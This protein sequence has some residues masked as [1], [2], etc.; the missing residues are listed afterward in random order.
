MNRI[1]ITLILLGFI[2]SCKQEY[3]C[4]CIC[5]EHVYYDF[6]DYQ[7]LSKNEVDNAENSCMN[8]NGT[9]CITDSIGTLSSCTLLEVP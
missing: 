7:S 2:S 8:K 5:N 9:E 4:Q 3:N 1:F 6:E